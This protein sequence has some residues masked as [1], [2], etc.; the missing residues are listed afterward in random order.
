LFN[1]SFGGLARDGLRGRKGSDA[2]GI[3]AVERVEDEVFDRSTAG[4]GRDDVAV[5][6]EEQRDLVEVAVAFEQTQQGAHLADGPGRV[7]GRAAAAAAEASPSRR[8]EQ[9]SLVPAFDLVC[10]HL[11]P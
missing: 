3:E 11:D 8:R 2:V 4:A 7:G 9:A 6:F 1:Q 5:E 10:R